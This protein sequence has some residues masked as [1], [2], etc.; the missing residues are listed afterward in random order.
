[1]KA[2]F[3]KVTG[4]LQ[5]YILRNWFTVGLD[6]LQHVILW[7]FLTLGINMAARIVLG[8]PEIA[9]SALLALIIGVGKEIYDKVSN[10][11]NMEALDV[12]AD[13][14]GIIGA[15]LIVYSLG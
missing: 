14:I 15:S 2:W 7:F 6:K 8:G 12:V 1:M 13:I 10:T 4:K 9:L 5:Q 11:G 3:Y